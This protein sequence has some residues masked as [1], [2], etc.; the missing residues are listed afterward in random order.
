MEKIVSVHVIIK[1]T[2]QGVGFRA[3]VEVQAHKSGVNG[4]VRNCPDGTVEVEAEGPRPVLEAFLLVLK[5]G[6]QYSMPIRK[7]HKTSFRGITSLPVC[8]L[9]LMEE[10]RDGL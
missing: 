4:W 1:G 8:R 2:V 6:P 7:V 10:V 3:F 5:Q 9:S